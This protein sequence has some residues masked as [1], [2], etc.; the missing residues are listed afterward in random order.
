MT[1]TLFYAVLKIYF[2]FLV[3]LKFYLFLSLPKRVYETQLSLGIKIWYRLNA[4][5]V[6][7]SNS[8]DCNSKMK[9]L[10]RQSVRI[11]VNKR[12]KKLRNTV[13]TITTWITGQL[14]GPNNLLQL[15]GIKCSHFV[16][17]R[18][19]ERGCKTSRHTSIH[20]TICY[21]T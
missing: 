5:D 1:F 2:K 19:V 6:C 8:M 20:I 7:H 18:V 9:T 17:N 16:L 4:V 15:H 12:I 13:V 3:N 11:Q 14:D 21:W 10:R